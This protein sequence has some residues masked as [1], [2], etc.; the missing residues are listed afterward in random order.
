MGNGALAIG[1]KLPRPSSTLPER[2]LA[3]AGCLRANMLSAVWVITLASSNGYLSEEAEMKLSIALSALLITGFVAASTE[4]ASAVVY[5]QYFE[6]PA[7]CIVR[8]GDVVAQTHDVRKIPPAIGAPARGFILR[9]DLF[10]RNDPNNLRSDYPGPP[11]Q[12]GQF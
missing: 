9:Q 3:L 10:D 6:Y 12:P 8:P 2:T 1:P 4:K 5:C 7:G 11:A